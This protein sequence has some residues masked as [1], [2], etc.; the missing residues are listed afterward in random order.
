MLINPFFIYNQIWV[1]GDISN[2]RDY[3]Y[4]SYLPMLQET[5]IKISYPKHSCKNCKLHK[6]DCHLIVDVLDLQNVLSTPNHLMKISANII[7]YSGVII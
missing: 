2:H 4:D 5:Y 3:N 1:K 6:S 7:M